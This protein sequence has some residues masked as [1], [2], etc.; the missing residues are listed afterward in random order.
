LVQW[1]L[2]ILNMKDGG[3]E[4]HVR[5]IFFKFEKIHEINGDDEILDLVRGMIKMMW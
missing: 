4:D 3:C 1:N 2:I 5:K